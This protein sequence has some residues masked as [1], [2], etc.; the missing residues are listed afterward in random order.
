MSQFVRFSF[1]LGPRMRS[2]LQIRDALTCMSDA[3]I[4]EHP[5]LWLHACAD[6]RLSLS[7]EQGR[8]CAVPDIIALLE[9]MQ[10]RLERLAG[11]HPRYAEKIMQSCAGLRQHA[12][13]LIKDGA[14]DALNIL[15][16]DAMI[17]AWQNSLKKHDWL[18]HQMQMPHTLQ[19]LWRNAA[20]RDALRQ[21][22]R[23]LS[24][25]VT[26]LHGMLHDYMDWETHL[27]RGGLDRFTLQGGKKDGLLI[28]GLRPELVESG[29]VPDVSANRMAVRLRFQ[30]WKPAQAAAPAEDD[31]EY[32]AMMVPVG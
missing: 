19:L 23:N 10:A 8:R 7:G 22:L 20:R 30:Q 6:L 31:I 27:A 16:S 15:N 18:G 12:D 5:Y 26:S 9:S 25:A 28:V 29:I 21:S 24:E 32:R 17:Q 4:A 1:P 2:F 11:E 13:N 3:E 14:S